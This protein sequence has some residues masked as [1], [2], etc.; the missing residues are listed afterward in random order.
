[1]QAAP[2]LGH[3]MSLVTFLVI[4]QLLEVTQEKLDLVAHG[5]MGRVQSTMAGKIWLAHRWAEQE[6]EQ[7]GSCGP[8]LASPFLFS[9][10]LGPQPTGCC[11][12]YSG[13]VYFLQLINPH[14]Q[15]PH[16]CTQRC[17]ILM[18]QIFLNPAKLTTEINHHRSIVCIPLSQTQ[19]LAKWQR[20]T[21]EKVS[22]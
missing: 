8:R 17:T 20:Q 16:K 5:V 10:S 3:R 9:V 13:R 2:S 11:R 1:M 7:K 21:N 19:G 15:H 14:W 18:P 12:L 4:K 22:W 6:A